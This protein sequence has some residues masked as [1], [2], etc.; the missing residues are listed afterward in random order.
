VVEFRLT[1]TTNEIIQLIKIA[2]RQV[3]DIMWAL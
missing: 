2:A 3:K 1:I